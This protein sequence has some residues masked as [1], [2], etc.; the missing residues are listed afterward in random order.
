[1]FA[2]LFISKE[3]EEEKV[4]ASFLFLFFLVIRIEYLHA[5]QTRCRETKVCARECLGF[6]LE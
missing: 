1:L 2:V 6:F 3:E 5:L 4:F